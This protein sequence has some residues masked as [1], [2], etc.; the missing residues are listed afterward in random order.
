MNEH[1]ASPPHFGVD[2]W[3]A[4]AEA[5]AEKA[6]AMGGSV[7]AGPL[8]GLSFRQTVLADPHGAASTVVRPV[9]ASQGA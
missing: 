6:A 2:H 8:D 3:T 1:R 5:A 7:V 4:D 9:A